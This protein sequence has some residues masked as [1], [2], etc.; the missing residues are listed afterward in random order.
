MVKIAWKVTFPLPLTGHPVTSAFLNRAPS[1]FRRS[2]D[3]ILMSLSGF[4]LLYLFSASVASLWHWIATTLEADTLRQKFRSSFFY[5]FGG[6]C[7][8]FLGPIMV[9]VCLFRLL[10]HRASLIP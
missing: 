2:L 10:F 6:V 8:F 1:N 3:T 9:P 4:A 5:F 7:A